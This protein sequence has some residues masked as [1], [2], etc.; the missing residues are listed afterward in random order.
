MDTDAG[1]QPRSQLLIEEQGGQLLFG[2]VCLC[3]CVLTARLVYA[4]GPLFRTWIKRAAERLSQWGGWG[5]NAG[6][7]KL[8]GPGCQAR[9]P[10]KLSPL[11]LRRIC[12]CCTAAAPRSLAGEHA[13]H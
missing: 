4:G 5:H 12:I 13:N 11:C 6:A 3:V 9:A 10:W 2:I 1:K 7:R 8:L